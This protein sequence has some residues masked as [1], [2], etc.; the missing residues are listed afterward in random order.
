MAGVVDFSVECF[1]RH[2]WGWDWECS[3][4]WGFLNADR[5]LTWIVQILNRQMEL[6]RHAAVVDQ[7]TITG[8]T[9]TDELMLS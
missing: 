4:Y 5:A 9:S 2:G 6:R 1:T 8:Q 3:F 7:V